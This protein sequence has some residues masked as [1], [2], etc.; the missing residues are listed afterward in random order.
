MRFDILEILDRKLQV[1]LATVAL[2]PGRVCGKNIDASN[3]HGIWRGNSSITD[4]Q[5][6]GA[7]FV[8]QFIE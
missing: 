6:G 4:I 7:V 5:F 2:Y 1:L 8:L 3:G